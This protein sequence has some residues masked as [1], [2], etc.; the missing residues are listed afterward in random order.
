MFLDRLKCG[1]VDVV[2]LN[3]WNAIK[4]AMLKDD[5]FARPKLNFGNLYFNHLDSWME[6]NGKNREYLRIVS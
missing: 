5:F 6:T 2:I 3:G 1:T 4:E